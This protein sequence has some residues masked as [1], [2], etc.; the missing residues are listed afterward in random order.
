VVW[1]IVFMMVIL[2]LPI[3]Y[4][5]GVVW[6]AIRAEPRPLEGAAVSVSAGPDSP[7]EPVRRFSR[8]RPLRR[9][10]QRGPSRAPARPARAVFARARGR[11]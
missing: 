4:L 7:V 9:G 11:R 3:V 5:C 8:R 2:K 1:E 6:W 10:P